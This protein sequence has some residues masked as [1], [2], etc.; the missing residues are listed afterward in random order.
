L[1]RIARAVWQPVRDTWVNQISKLYDW[2]YRID[3][4]V[5][6]GSFRPQ[7]TDDNGYEPAKYGTL[8][9]LRRRIPV[10]PSDVFYD[11]GCG[12]GRVTCMFAHEHMQRVIGIEYLPELAAIAQRNAD[13]TSSRTPIEI[14]QGDAG[15]QDYSDG[16]IFFLYNPFGADTMHRM[17]AQIHESLL[18]RP[19]SIRLIYMN[20]SLR[21]IFEQT[22][23]LQQVE[24]FRIPYN[25][26]VLMD[27]SV[28]RNS[29]ATQ[30]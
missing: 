10:T 6:H 23:W 12:K 19:R 27:V 18:T 5:P 13:A 15:A 26:G 22:T 24:I 25:I 21:A 14:R 9:I 16:T 17:L 4:H 20:D 8:R 11:I 28:W 29:S 2:H 30:G 7:F 3:T 1:K